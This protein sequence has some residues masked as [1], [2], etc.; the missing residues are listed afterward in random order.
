MTFQDY[1]NKY[2]EKADAG[3][4][5]TILPMKD[6]VKDME[7]VKVYKC[8]GAYRSDTFCIK[9]PIRKGCLSYVR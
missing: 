9:C 6:G 4:H 2:V 8:F 3:L 5:Q 1:I 7:G